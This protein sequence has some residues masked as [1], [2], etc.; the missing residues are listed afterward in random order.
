VTPSSSDRASRPRGKHSLCHPNPAKA[1]SMKAV[2]PGKPEARLQALSTGAWNGRRII[3]RPRGLVETFAA[4]FCQAYVTGNGLA[5]L[6]DHE[7]LLQTIYDDDTQPLEAVAVDEVSGKIA[8]CTNAAVR[9]YSPL[10]E[11]EHDLR[12]WQGVVRYNDLG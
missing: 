6:S 8:V 4:D 3:V 11:E 1:G 2:L 7:S 9:V 12:V 5:I 10:G